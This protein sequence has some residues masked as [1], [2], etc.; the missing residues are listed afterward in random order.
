[1][2]ADIT[3]IEE[4]RELVHVGSGPEPLPAR[5]LVE[6]QGPDAGHGLD[7]ESNAG[8][9]QP[10]GTRA[11]SPASW[12]SSTMGTATA[13]ASMGRPVARR[14]SSPEAL[15]SVSMVTSRPGQIRP[16]GGW[17]AVTTKRAPRPS[18]RRGGAA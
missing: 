5:G 8:P 17:A 9:G 12:V 16:S 18:E 1:M 15:G 13:P 7:D 6:S 14:I 11:M 4:T 10:E 2:R 3:S